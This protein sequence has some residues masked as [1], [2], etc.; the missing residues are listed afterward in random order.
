MD[1]FFIIDKPKGIT[2]QGVVSQIKKKFQLKKCGHTG[3][4]DPDATGVLVVACGSAT[5]LVRLLEEK[6]KKYFTTIVF[7]YDSN[8]LDCYGQVTQNI[9]M[10]F[11]VEELDKALQQL[12]TQTEQIPPMVSAIKVNGKKLYEYERKNQQVEVAARPIKIYDIVR[13]SELR[14]CENH[15]EIDLEITCS[16][17]F[18]VRSFARDLGNLL[19]GCAILKNLRR[20]QSGRF[21]IENAIKL[22]DVKETDLLSIEEVF[23][24]YEVLEVNSFIANLVK[25]GVVLDERQIKT[26][27]PFYIQH[28][29]AIIA[30]YEPVGEFLYKPVIIFK[31]R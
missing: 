30:I 2:S 16:K 15:L 6:E 18:Y 10:Q 13:K 20:L 28:K 22:E 11:A 29:S 26:T 5:K 8:T 17:G 27:S 21:T 14:L 25:N 31:E 3:T 1:G 4:L 23:N 9:K 24:E 7:G 12:L 19:G